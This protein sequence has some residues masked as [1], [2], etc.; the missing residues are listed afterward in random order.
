MVVDDLQWADAATASALVTLSRRLA[1]H[2]ISWL[3]A[4]RRAELADAAQDAVDRLEVA[5]A[6]EIRLGPLDETAVAQ[7]ARDMLGG[8][9]DEALRGVLSRA[10]GQPFLLTELLRGLR[11]ENLVTVDGNTA[12]LAVGARLPRLPRRLVDSVADEL[13]RLTGP[14]RDAVTAELLARTRA[15]LPVLAGLGEREELLT[16]AWLASLRAPRTRRAYASDIQGWLGWLTERGTDVLDAGRV[17]V[18]MWAAGQQDQG[19]E[20]ASVRRR[21]SA[22]SSFYRYCAAH[23]LVDRIPTA[24]V[25]RPVVDPDYTATIGLDRDQVRALV[26]AADAD[27]R[28]QALRTAAVIRLL[29]HNA[30]RVD[31]A[32][33][34][35]VADLGANAGPGS[36]TCSARAPGKR[37]SRWPRPRQPRWT[38][39]LRTGTPGRAQRHAAAGRPAAGHRQ[40]R[41]PP[42]R[43]PVGTGAPPG[44]RRRHPGLGPAIPALPAALGDHLRPRRW[45]GP[46]RCPG[47]RRPQGPPHDPPV[48]LRPGQPGPQRR[49]RG[50][51]LPRLTRTHSRRPSVARPLRLGPGADPSRPELAGRSASPPPGLAELSGLSDLVAQARAPRRGFNVIEHRPPG[52]RPGEQPGG[53][54]RIRRWL[55]AGTEHQ[56]GT[57]SLITC[58]PGRV[59]TGTEET[60]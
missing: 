50:R 53:D 12:K 40:R 23:D 58:L 48:R 17:H 9:P 8:E 55:T 38:P 39:T 27:R 21:L 56:L 32:C 13:A 19:A 14:A 34:A 20:A 31:E 33:A 25:A 44:P 49:L 1:T 5:G 45:R 4:L 35:D 11:T 24:G 47:L 60:G 22:L 2:R 54:P 46:A 59:T 57:Q 15:E 36:C 42:P 10:D 41:P 7:V 37:E 26:A 16:A 28:P 43:A 30:L 52:P 6:S 51:G 18:D 29:V 3:L